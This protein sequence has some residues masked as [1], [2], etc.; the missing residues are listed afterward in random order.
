MERIA[1]LKSREIFDII[2]P[3]VGA[4]VPLLEEKRAEIQE[5][6]RKTFKY[7]PTDRHQLDVYYPLAPNALG[8]TQILVW[9]Y[10][11]GFVSGERQLPAPADL[12]Y[13][14]VGAYF[15][16]RGF[17]VIIPDYRLAPDT[18][19]P[20]AAEDVRDAILWAIKNPEQLTTPTTP[21]PD[22]KGIFLSGHSAGAV[23]AF[24]AL[25]IPETPETSIRSN[26]AG[27]ILAAG[28]PHYD[29]FQPDDLTPWATQHYVDE[30]GLKDHAP[31]A[32]LRNASD[33]TVATLPRIVLVLAEWEPEWLLK[34][35]DEF[36]GELES[37]TGKR[38]AK[39][40]GRRHNHLSTNLALGT[41]RGEEWAE[42][43]IAWIKA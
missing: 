9:L 26:I 15:A 34:I 23:H 21:N 17:I 29:Y 20:G 1:E 16:R 42:D 22:T 33:A 37:R 6:T 3:T 7:G 5:I 28:V 24:T 14:C 13:A 11:G 4:F 39:I 25:V 38:P 18:V 31:R 30:D 10:G 32:L 19:F 12:A 35:N 41:G 8:K 36:V 43:V 40:V 2:E 27:A